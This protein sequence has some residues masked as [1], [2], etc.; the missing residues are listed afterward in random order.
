LKFRIQHRKE[1]MHIL[2]YSLRSSIQ[3][4]YYKYI[5]HLY[6]ATKTNWENLIRFL[7][8]RM[9][10]INWMLHATMDKDSTNA[11]HLIYPEHKNIFA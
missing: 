4:Y 10:L 7:P 8:L 9:M 2:D 6:K 5:F 1:L 3:G 11:T